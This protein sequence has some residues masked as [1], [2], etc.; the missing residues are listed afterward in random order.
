MK[1]FRNV[2][3]SSVNATIGE[4]SLKTP[5]EIKD[6]TI[7]LEELKIHPKYNPLTKDN[8][9]AVIKLK[10]PITIHPAVEPICLP[11]T[12][13]LG[14]TYTHKKVTAAGWGKMDGFF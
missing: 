4:F 10:E 6:V 11:P 9:I 8:D 7:S 5:E 3:L 14:P 13:G 12:S 1:N 2:I